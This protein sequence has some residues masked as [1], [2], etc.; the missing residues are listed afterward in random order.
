VRI[1][2]AAAIAAAL[3]GA[4]TIAITAPSAPKEEVEDPGV[5]PI[6]F[7]KPLKAVLFDHAFHV[8]QQ[9]GDCEACHDE[10]F[11]QERGATQRKP[12]FTMKTM[13]EEGTYCGRCHEEDLRKDCWS[14]HIGR[15]GLRRFRAAH[16]DVEIPGIEEEKSAGG[17]PKA[18]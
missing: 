17:R 8:K 11:E 1:R 6:V 2:F 14:C 18:D 7:V 12:D 16:P 4:V 10:L 3:G 13:E 5:E 9:K 15:S